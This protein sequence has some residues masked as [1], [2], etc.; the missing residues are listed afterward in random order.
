MS[1]RL[2][3][4]F[5]LSRYMRAHWTDRIRAAVARGHDVHVAVPVDAELDG[6]D[7]SGAALHDLPL[8]RGLP[9][10][11]GEIVC[12]LAIFR[13]L[14]ALKPDLLHAVTI[15]PVVYGGVAAR[16]L[17]VPAVLHSLTGLGF[18][19]ASSGP[20]ARLLRPLVE[21]ALRFAFGHAN[22]RVLF[23]NH[24]DC[25]ELVGHGVVAP[26]RTSVFIGSGLDLAA[27][28]PAPMPEREAPLVTLP[29]RLI[30][31]KG[32][33]EFVAAARRLRGEGSPARFA[34]VGEGDPGNP[35]SIAPE[36][37]EGWAR[38]GVVECWGWQDDIVSVLR[39]S[40]LVCLPSWYREGAPR[41]LIEAA[42]MG[43][44][45]VTT[46]WPGCRDVVVDGV[47]GLL[48]PPRDAGA[49]ANALRRL[50]ADPARCEAMGVAARAHAEAAF[51]NERAFAHLFALYDALLAKSP[52]KV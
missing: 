46:D 6:L 7:L 47:T 23:E 11:W 45:A 27:F 33:H 8:R 32:V 10:P 9:T 16:L 5:P 51:S 1:D 37:L 25:A 44:P 40:T 48:V 12:F 29:S 26:D 18:L 14:R 3:F 38:E 21:R 35:E 22:A 41:I 15:R 36:T 13:L 52:R 20:A 49:L 50:L 28:A 2:L 31:P 42:A 17:H 34:L 30:A 39:A 24:D 19:Y 43:R 4:L